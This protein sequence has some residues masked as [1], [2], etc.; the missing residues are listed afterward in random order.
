MNV[1]Y[2]QRRILITNDKDFGFL[3]IRKRKKYKGV[4]LLRL[5]KDSPLNRIKIIKSLI[6]TF[7]EKLKGKFII[8]SEKG[9]RIRRI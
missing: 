6:N 2:R 9:V 4:I 5:R 7:G 3:I 1:A 8:A